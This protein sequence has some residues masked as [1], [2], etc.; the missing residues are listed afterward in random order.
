MH[1][2]VESKNKLLISAATVMAVLVLGHSDLW[3]ARAR[4]Q[5]LKLEPAKAQVDVPV[6]D[7]IEQPSEN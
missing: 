5:G 3:N 2:K 6:V 4:A 7:H 1:L